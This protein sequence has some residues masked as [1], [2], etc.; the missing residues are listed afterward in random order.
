MSSGS[1]DVHH[2]MD[3]SSACFNLK[4][5]RMPRGLRQPERRIKAKWLQYNG[6][7]PL[8]FVELNLRIC[9]RIFILNEGLPRRS[10]EIHRY[11]VTLRI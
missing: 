9:S 5:G 6:I 1:D 3:E 8:A 4:R 10:Q 2:M 7:K 11:P